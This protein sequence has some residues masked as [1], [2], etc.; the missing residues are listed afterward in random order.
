MKSVV[1]YLRLVSIIFLVTFVGACSEKVEVE[2]AVVKET[3]ADSSKSEDKQ[4]VPETQVYILVQPSGTD[5]EVRVNDI[6]VRVGITA[7]SLS[8]VDIEPYLVSGENELSI[9]PFKSSGSVSVEMTS[10]TV[11]GNGMIYF[12]NGD[13]LLSIRAEGER[14]VG[15]VNFPSARP[16]WAWTNADFIDDS[17]SRDEAIR[18]SRLYYEALVKGDVDIV[19]PAHEPIFSDQ[20]ILEPFFSF[21]ERM[22]EL[23]ADLKSNAVSD[24]WLFDDFDDIGIELQPVASGRLFIVRRKDGSA[25]FR[26]SQSNPDERIYYDSMIGRKNGK[27]AFYL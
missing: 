15:T 26:T 27:W 5:G 12:N 7:D 2:E 14:G 22:E 1:V 9:L 25:L 13:V 19:L 18:F 17:K 24:F 11:D 21:D 20:S 6:P 4:V 10:H 23:E 16:I 3:V 8:H